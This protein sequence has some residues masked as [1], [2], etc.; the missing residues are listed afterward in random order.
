MSSGIAD[1][2]FTEAGKWRVRRAILILYVFVGVI[3]FGFA[4]LQ[5]DVPGSGVRV[6]IGGSALNGG[7]A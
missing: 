2:L 1:V 7:R 5:S 3:T 6:A 4:R